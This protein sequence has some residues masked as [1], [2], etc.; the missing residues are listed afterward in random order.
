MRHPLDLRL[1]LRRIDRRPRPAA[2]RLAA[3]SP[4]DETTSQSG[5]TVEQARRLVGPIVTPPSIRPT[6]L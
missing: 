1:S 2:R 3:A 6:P 5:F 4:A